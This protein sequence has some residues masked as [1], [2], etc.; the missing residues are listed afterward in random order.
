MTEK[1]RNNYLGI[2]LLA[3]CVGGIIWGLLQRKA[4][5]ENYALTS[6]QVYRYSIGGRGNAG[7]IWI[8]FTYTI[9]GEKYNSSSRFLTSELQSST[10]EKYMLYKTLPAIYNPANPSNAILLVQPKDFERFG[11]P[12]PDSLNWVKQLVVPKDN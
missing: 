10:I 1:Q 7:G 2:L 5:N 6:A 8:D 12:F 11:Y 4:L 3:V 9:K